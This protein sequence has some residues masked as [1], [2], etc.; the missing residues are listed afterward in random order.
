MDI[1]GTADLKSRFYPALLDLASGQTLQK[2]Y[3]CSAWAG[4]DRRQCKGFTLYKGPGARPAREIPKSFPVWTSEADDKRRDQPN[5]LTWSVDKQ[6][7]H[8]LRHPT[9]PVTA[10]LRTLGFYSLRRAWADDR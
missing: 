3:D 5:V 7:D 10:R 6:S 2:L 8:V 1:G 9:C 4:I